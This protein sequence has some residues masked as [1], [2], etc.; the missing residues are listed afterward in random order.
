MTTG[1][2][3]TVASSSLGGPGGRYSSKSGPAAAAKKAASQRFRAASS[4]SKTI[5]LTMR[6]LGSDKEF[7][8]EATRVKLPKPFVRKIKG[9]TITSEYKVEIK[10]L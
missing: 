2:N 8:Y 1:T 3:Y 6:Q 10:A 4:G 5:R 7:K 9:V